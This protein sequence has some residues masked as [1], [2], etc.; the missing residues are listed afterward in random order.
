M[1]RNILRPLALF[2][3]LTLAVLPLCAAAKEGD[4]LP[5]DLR[6]HWSSPY[7]LTMLEAGILTGYP[8]GRFYPD[9]PLTR[10]EAACLLY[11][12]FSGDA[13]SSQEAPSGT[14]GDI[15][16]RWSR[17]MIQSLLDWGVLD[18]DARFSPAT[19]ITRGEMARYT[20]R[21]LE[22]RAVAAPEQ[23][24]T[25]PEPEPLAQGAAVPSLADQ[26]QP[27]VLAMVLAEGDRTAPDDAPSPPEPAADGLPP[28]HFPDLAEN[29]DAPYIEALYA[30]NIVNGGPDGLFHPGDSLTRGQGAAIL[31]RASGLSVTETTY[32]PLPG[33]LVIPVPYISQVY[34]VNAPV[35]C[36]PT[37]LLMGLKAKGYAQEVELRQ[38]LDEMP[39]TSANP[40]KGFVGSPYV[41]DPSKRTRTT[42]YPPI[43]AEYGSRYGNVIDIS[44]AAPALLQRE[45]LSGNP[46]VAYVTLYWAKPYYRMFNIEG[47]TQ[48]LL[49]NNHAVLV[50]G[51]NG[52]THQYYIADPYNVK[53]PSKEY[54][55]WV[56][57]LTFD[58]LYLERCHALTVD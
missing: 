42:I 43:L 19:P 34:P 54:F 22:L 13:P 5:L 46:V 36:E 56:D 35:G 48:R 29:P 32:P 37:A 16:G 3:A 12:L 45:I 8:N 52:E 30:K 2:L 9:Q 28:L 25:P 51:Y 1:Y 50:C 18:P 20:A 41:P 38:F 6:D 21:C 11:R 27:Q 14:F 31:L 17:E 47:E 10:E 24:V 33:Y 23:A 7:A 40:A 15:E 44:G 53:N 26:D 49:S 55:Y 57:G 58:S 39:K 4:K